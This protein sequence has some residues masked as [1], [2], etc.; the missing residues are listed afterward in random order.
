MF[1]SRLAICLLLFG[2]AA[3]QPAA[4]QADR[5][6]LLAAWEQLLASQPATQRFEAT[7]DETYRLVDTDLP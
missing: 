3:A 1:K 5:E 2:I 7:G 6:S 4:A